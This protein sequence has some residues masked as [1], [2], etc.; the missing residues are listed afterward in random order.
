VQHVCFQTISTS[1]HT[2]ARS[3]IHTAWS[4]RQLLIRTCAHRPVRGGCRTPAPYRSH[5]EVLIWGV[6]AKPTGVVKRRSHRWRDAGKVSS[7]VTSRSTWPPPRHGHPEAQRWRMPHTVERID[8]VNEGVR[9]RSFGSHHV[10]CVAW[11]PSANASLNV[12]HALHMHRPVIR[13]ALET[14]RLLVGRCRCRHDP[15]HT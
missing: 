15:L 3:S 6:S 12:A 2:L 8:L 5:D 10:C 1:R 14:H 7:S 9:R 13:S 4:R 11:A